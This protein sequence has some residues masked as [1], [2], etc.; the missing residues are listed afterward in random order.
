MQ[1]GVGPPAFG[2]AGHCRGCRYERQGQAQGGTGSGPWVVM[3][4][5]TVIMIAVV[6]C[7]PTHAVTFALSKFTVV[8]LCHVGIGRRHSPLATSSGRKQE[9]PFDEQ[10]MGCCCSPTS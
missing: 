5:R 1:Y 7:E 2:V 8:S 10:V 4:E 6:K 9:Q 3:S